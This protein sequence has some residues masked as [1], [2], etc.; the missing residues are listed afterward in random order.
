MVASYTV[1]SSLQAAM[2]RAGLNPTDVEVRWPLAYL[3]CPCEDW[4]ICSNC[5][6]VKSGSLVPWFYEPVF[7]WFYEPI[8]FFY[9]SLSLCTFASFKMC[10]SDCVLPPCVTVCVVCY[11]H[12]IHYVWCVTTMC[13]ILCCVLPPFDEFCLVCHHYVLHFVLC[14]T[15]IWYILCCVLPP[16]DT[17]CVVCYLLLLSFE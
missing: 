17:F 11:H 15:T 4:R 13:Y 7:L 3:F 1:Y 5:S 10:S 16:C 14:V 9:F 12:V 8:L 2:R 6:S